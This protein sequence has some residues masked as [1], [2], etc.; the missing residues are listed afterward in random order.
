MYSCTSSS[1]K[2]AAG[3]GEDT[4]KWTAAQP[5]DIK[6]VQQYINENNTISTDA[7]SALFGFN[8]DDMKNENIIFKI[9]NASIAGKGHRC[10]EMKMD[11]KIETLKKLIPEDIVESMKYTSNVKG[12]Q[13]KY[14]V[15]QEMCVF[16]EF[17]FR[18]YDSIKKDGKRWFFS[19]NDH[20]RFY[21]I[22]FPKKDKS[23]K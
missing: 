7:L 23:K 18:Y 16:V 10:R 14:H 3:G 19:Y 9:K 6:D 22:L 2:G 8:G 4:C 5:E 15:M 17:I 21:N 12:K 13:T 20:H 1:K 11:S